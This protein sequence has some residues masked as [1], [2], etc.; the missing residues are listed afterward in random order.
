MQSAPRVSLD[1]LCNFAWDSRKSISSNV[2][3]DYLLT[4]FG[5]AWIELHM[6][7]FFTSGKDFR[8][9]LQYG[10]KVKVP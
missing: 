8:E 5:S 1:F 9:K 10:C 6:M 3:N 2:Q 4:W 7:H